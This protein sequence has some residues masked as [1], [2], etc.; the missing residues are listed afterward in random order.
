MRGGMGGFSQSL[1]GMGRSFGLGQLGRE[2][3]A[4]R[5][6]IRL[7]GALIRRVLGYFRPYRARSLLILACLALASVL[8]LA[9][10]LLVRAILDRAL[11]GRDLS[12][13]SGL[14]AGL[15]LLP[16]IT[17][18]I[19]V[20]QNYWHVRISQ[21]LMFDIRND[22]Y[23]HLQ[24][25]SLRFYTTT[26]AGEI[27]SRVNNDVGAVQGVVI[28][29]V[30]GIVTNLLT[31]VA[32]AAVLLAMD[33]RLALLACAIVPAFLLPT[34]RIGRVRHRLA[35]ET[36][37]KQAELLALMQDVLNIGGFILMRLFG[38]ADYEANRFRD[39]NREVLDLQMKQAMTGRWMFMFLSVIASAGPALIYW[40][41]GWRIIDSDGAEPTL[42][43]GTIIAFVAYLANLYRPAG[44][45]ANIYVDVQGALA[46]FVRI[47]E[48]LDMD[49]EVSDRPS[50]RPLPASAGD[51]RFEHVTFTYKAG[52]R[53][54][55]ADVSFEIPAGRMAAL[56]GPSGAGKTTATYLVPRFYDPQ[57]GRVC[58]GGHDLRDVALRSLAAHVGMVTQE[59]FLFHATV[60]E[61]LLYARPQATG[62]ELEA[63]VRAANIYDFISALPDGYDTIVG[64][65]GF[66]LSGGERQRLS[67]ARA[68]LKD[69][70]ILV[71]DEATSSLDSESEAAIQAAMIPLMKGRTTLVIAHRLSTVL[72]ADVILVLEHGRLVE[73]GTHPELLALNG[74]YT[75]LYE[76]QFLRHRAPLETPEG[77][78]DA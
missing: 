49:P 45:L 66:K 31:I 10:P 23:R 3:D 21:C 57:S 69:P 20:L 47:F 24:R 38:Q 13:L 67:I 56:V 77:E 1:G 19:G 35:R 76:R 9:P 2:P 40:Y 37:A 72:A 29:T 33:W 30:V 62:A 34:R 41:G 74:L 65:R 51:V 18:L 15:I 12:L 27:L 46:V 11:P 58:I 68:I 52:H 25:L 7:E 64:E 42:T 60:R 61:N 5:P 6:S 59:T 71:L 43:I 50:A 54:A 16:V 53:P 70:R 48:Y 78:V 44:Q 39:R 8:G 36:Q 75:R 28:S 17:G 4:G 63:A 73:Q 14:V 55:L 32:T 22:L 26:R